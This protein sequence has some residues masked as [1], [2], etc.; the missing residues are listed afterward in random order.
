[1]YAGLRMI[2]SLA[3]VLSLVLAFTWSGTSELSSACRVVCFFAVVGYLVYVLFAILRD[4]RRTAI[5]P[6][7]RAMLP[8]LWDLDLDGSGPIWLGS[9]VAHRTGKRRV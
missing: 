8:D 2:H 7:K 3:L 5:I 4:G 1:M 9:P 6:S